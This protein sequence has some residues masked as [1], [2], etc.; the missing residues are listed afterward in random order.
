MKKKIFAIVVFLFLFAGN[1]RMQGQTDIKTISDS[2]VNIYKKE[3]FQKKD[4]TEVKTGWN[5]IPFPIVGY[6][7]DYGFMF[8]IY[9]CIWNFGDGAIFPNYYHMFDFLARYNT[10]VSGVFRLYYDSEYLIPNF[11]VGIDV[12]YMLDK[13]YDFYGMNGFESPFFEEKPH[14]YYTYE[15]SM[16]RIGANIFGKLYENLSWGAGFCYNKSDISR[17]NLSYPDTKTLYDYYV[18]E[19]IFNENE[20]SGGNNF[21]LK[22]GVFYDSRDFELAPKKGIATEILFLGSP[23]FINLNETFSY[24]YLQLSINHR[25]FIPLFN[26]RLILAYRIAYQGVLFGEMPFYVL[27]DLQTFFPVKTYNDGLGGEASIRGLAPRKVLGQGMAW[28][29]IEPRIHIVDF[30]A[31]KQKFGIHVNPFFDMGMVVQPFRQDRITNASDNI[32]SGKKEHLHCS[33]GIGLKLHVN[34]S[35]I[36]NAEF[37]FP[38]NKLDGTVGVYLGTNYLF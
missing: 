29:N 16:I 20:K 27:Q 9:S 30:R 31:F 38:L 21:N 34:D 28:F 3:L 5:F 14:S 24:S 11:R 36:A 17:G 19:G 32:Y 15:R 7:T 35:F 23:D 2:L 33:Y 6:S 13:A 37:G 10:N 22:A 4:T 26:E 1:F 12:S 8:G 18:S 25:Q